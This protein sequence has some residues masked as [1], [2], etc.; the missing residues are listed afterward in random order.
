MGLPELVFTRGAHEDIRQ[1]R[2]PLRAAVGNT[3]EAL[4]VEPRRVGVPLLGRLRGRWSARVGNYRIVYTIEGSS[5]H[6]R[7][8]VRAVRHRSIAYGRRRRRP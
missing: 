2:E 3:L 8:V 4:A 1:L 7:V 6:E 5:E